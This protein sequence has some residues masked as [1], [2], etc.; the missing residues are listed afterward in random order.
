MSQN[1][2]S[3]F[4]VYV[5]GVGPSSSHSMGPE[6]AARLR[7]IWGQN[8]GPI[9][10]YAGR[11]VEEKRPDVLIRALATINQVQ[12]RELGLQRGANVV[13]P[14]LTPVEYRGRYEIYPGKACVSETA[15]ECR[16]CLRGRIESIGRTVGVGQGGRARRGS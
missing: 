6:R 16:L 3:I 2:Q 9:I 7:A 1:L 4:E 14:N 10:G 12:G 13:M 5:A 15:E 11:F 8:G